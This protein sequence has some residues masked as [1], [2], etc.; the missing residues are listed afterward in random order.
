VPG[1]YRIPRIVV[2]SRLVSQLARLRRDFTNLALGV[3][4]SALA[5]KAFAEAGMT[6]LMVGGA[7]VEGENVQRFADWK[8][9]ADEGL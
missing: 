5:A 1:W 2:E 9:L 7:G 4:D 3:C 8:A 6:V